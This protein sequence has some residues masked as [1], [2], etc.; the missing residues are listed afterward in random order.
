MET[1]VQ[2]LGPT[3]VWLWLRAG[4][5]A[6]WGTPTAVRRRANVQRDGM[7]D[8]RHIETSD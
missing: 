4:K 1:G 7:R 5:S 6:G 2:N 8:G 3:G